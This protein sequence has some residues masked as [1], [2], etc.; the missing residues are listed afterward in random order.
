MSDDAGPAKAPDALTLPVAATRNILRAVLNRRTNLAICRGIG[1]NLHVRASPARRSWI[2]P[3]GALLGLLLLGGDV[4]AD[5][6]AAGDSL[7][8]FFDPR[9]IEGGWQPTTV[10]SVIQSHDGY[11]WLGTYHGLVRFD[12]VRY[13]VFDTSN[14]REL[15]NG[16]ITALYEDPQEVLW[17]GHETGDLTQ[18][19]EDK[20][21][22]V[23][24]GPK[25]PGGAI[26]A[27]RSDEN[28]DLWLMNG[29]GLLFRLRDG[30][31]TE[32]PGGASPTQKAS[33]TRAHDGKLWVV[34][35]GRVA[36]VERGVA[37]PFEFGTTN[38]ADFYEQVTPSRDGGL[39]VLANERI[40]KWRAG[41]WVS[42]LSGAPPG[43]GS[44]TV[45]VETRAGALLVG[46]L[47]EGLRL[48]APGS[49][50]VHFNRTNGLSHDWV[51]SVCEDHEGSIW[52]GTGAGFDGLRPRKVNM[53][54]APDSWQGCAVLS[55]SVGADGSAWIGT[56]GAGLYHY[57]REK[58]TRFEESS[59]LS[60]AFVWSVLETRQGDIFAGTWGAGL[61]VRNGDRFET[62]RGLD[63]ITAP[64]A[65]LYQGKGGE[66]W[67]GTATGLHRYE[68]GKL[69]WSAGKDRLALPDVRA[70]AESPDGT[71][72]F[73]MS[74]GGLGELKNG[75][76][77]QF[78]KG[79]GPGSDFIL[80]L[81]V[82]TDGTLWFGTGDNGIGCC[83]EGRFSTITTAQGLSSAVISHLVSDGEGNLWMGSQLG[84]LR[85]GRADLLRCAY[86]LAPTVRCLS[87][88]AAHGLVSLNCSGGFQ[89]GACKAPDGRLWFPTSKGVAIVDPTQVAINPIPPPVVVEEF[90]VDGQPVSFRPAAAAARAAG[91]G[92]TLRI[93]PGKQR[94]EIRY[95][96]LSFAAPDKVRFRYK[97]EG[98]EREWMEA[99]TKRVAP[100]SYLPPGEYVFRV[101]A[102]NNDGVWNEVGASLAFIVMPFLWQTWW[103]QTG[104]ILA[105]AGAIAAG[106]L[107]GTRRRVRRKLERLERQRAIERERARIARD[108]HDELGASLTRIILL[109]QAARSELEGQPKAAASVDQIYL[110]ARQLTREMDEIVWAVNPQHDS[111]DSLVAYLGSFAQSFLSAAGIRCRLDL[112]LHP[113]AWSL[114]AEIRHNVFLA[115]KEALNNVVKH[116]DASEVRISLELKPAGFMLVVTD[117]GRGFRWD[118]ARGQAAPQ[119]VESRSAP[120]NGLAN[121][122]KRLEQI[123]GACAWDTAPGEGTRAKII[124]PLQT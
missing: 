123:G 55:L 46:T 112:P 120:G 26:E 29:S 105:G 5:P 79:D 106:V 111:L 45:L 81:Q 50:P 39:W 27:I 64:V 92:S 122:Q 117:N 54:N 42:E 59:G 22:P 66:I 87:Y 109:G 89:P 33:L 52:L 3:C 65:S 43:A 90:T 103:F 94:F 78:R 119:P 68:G 17:I 84:I 102:C 63:A 21:Q 86:S 100:Y 41:Q 67:I 60:N 97:L 25:W 14:T 62:P 80:C 72:W 121:M 18:F 76:L 40:R 28:G 12:G 77:R 88:G 9:R 36:T 124:V 7:M 35:S 71:L 98:L 115:F 44:V 19:R 2:H 51:R 93:P 6:P 49:P 8:A 34:S 114:S 82:D 75:A 85:V 16:L 15:R 57:E 56:E 107:W 99:G 69:T 48:L 23:E 104:S 110:T 13:T 91:S 30:H 1:Q 32:A 4:R 31:T 96:G 101:V 20:F 53:L 108:I 11:L 10:T 58:W 37:V 118:P 95:T 83:R 74:G 47:R 70:I 73:G 113:P 61:R 24:L 116:A 38:G